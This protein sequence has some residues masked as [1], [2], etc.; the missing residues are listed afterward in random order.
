MIMMVMIMTI[1]MI[2]DDNCDDEHDSGGGD[3]DNDD[4]DDDNDSHDDDSDDY[5]SEDYDSYNFEEENKKTR[6]RLKPSKN[7]L[8]NT[9][10][11]CKMNLKYF[12]QLC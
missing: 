10:L 7:V 6:T 9:S 5:D 3:Y 12:Y 1:A 11:S 4:G 8:L 2:A